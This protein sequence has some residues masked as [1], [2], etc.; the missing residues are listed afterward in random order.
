MAVTLK[1]SEESSLHL[2]LPS[3]LEFEEETN[4]NVILLLDNNV[5]LTSHTCFLSFSP[6]LKSILTNVEVRLDKPCISMPGF[7]QNTV[8][9]L[10]QFLHRGY[11]GNNRMLLQMGLGEG[12]ILDTRLREDKCRK[13]FF[14]R[15]LV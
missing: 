6:V 14:S 4:G 8:Q 3:Q 9:H 11:V 2:V 10:L 15:K 12:V 13:E 7:S 5:R 1:R